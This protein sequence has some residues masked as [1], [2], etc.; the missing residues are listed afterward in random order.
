M[1]IPLHKKIRMDLLEKINNGFYQENDTIPTELELSEQ[2]GVSRPTVRQAVQALVNEGYLERRKKRGTIVKKTK[3]KQEFTHVIE[4]FDS[5]MNRK[6]ISP[7]TNVLNFSIE[8]ANEEVSENLNIEP[9]KE[10]YKLVR[11]R[12][13]GEDPLVTVTTYIPK[14]MFP[15]LEEVDFSTQLLYNVFKEFNY[16]IQSVSRKLEVIKAD[17]TTSD[18]LNI[19][20]NDPI[21]YF[22]T[23]GFTHDKIAIEY[24]I[25]K[26]RGDI[27]YFVFEI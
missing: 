19:E 9:N 7:K 20:E 26:Y 13:A 22:H 8:H 2:Y 4:S 14:E 23:Q 16:P 18:L 27:N 3:I 11:L 25:S 12:Y 21:F 5:E 15:K 17:E 24:S 6:G 10:V 1:K